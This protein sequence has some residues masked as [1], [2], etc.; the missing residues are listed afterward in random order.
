MLDDPAR[1]AIEVGNHFLILSL[2]HHPG[3]Q[4]SAP[5]LHQR[6]VSAVIPAELAEIVGVR[7]IATEQDRKAGKAGVNRVSPRVDDARIGRRKMNETG[8]PEVRRAPSCR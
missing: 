8:K 5:V 3:R 2:Q 1:L 6:R 4:H 7:L